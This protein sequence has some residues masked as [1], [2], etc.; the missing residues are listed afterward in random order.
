MQD[1]SLCSFYIKGQ[2]KTHTQIAFINTLAVCGFAVS[3]AGFL[4]ITN[5]RI[6]ALLSL[7][8]TE[9]LSFNTQCLMSHLRK[10]DFS[11][12]WGISKF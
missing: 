6:R 11:S 9:L 1:E 5:Y 4:H 2:R 12:V 10:T 7:R 8:F 3:K